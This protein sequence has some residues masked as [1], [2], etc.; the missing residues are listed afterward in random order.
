MPMPLQE[1]ST[2]CMLGHCAMCCLNGDVETVQNQ[3]IDYA[4]KGMQFHGLE[5]NAGT[6]TIRCNDVN[7]DYKENIPVI[8][9]HVKNRGGWSCGCKIQ[10]QYTEDF[11]SRHGNWIQLLSKSQG[12][13]Y[14]GSKWIPEFHHMHQSG[15]ILTNCDVHVCKSGNRHRLS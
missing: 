13:L 8:A 4:L 2:F 11:L 1:A 10:N 12:I 14:K 7:G 5:E 9:S 15:H 6:G 3:Q